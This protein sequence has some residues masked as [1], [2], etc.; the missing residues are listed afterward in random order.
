MSVTIPIT[1]FAPAERV[2]IEVI[3]LQH[4]AIIESPMT[5]ELLN[6]VINYV[7]ILN[8]QRQIVY[9]SSNTSSILLGKSADSILGMRPGEALGCIHKD[10]NTSG[11]GT[12]IFCSECGAVKAML[13]SFQGNKSVQECRLTRIVNLE[14]EAI[15]LLVCAVPFTYQNQK[16]C[17]FSIADV[18]HEKRRRALERIFFHDVINAAG[19]LEGLADLLESEAPVEMRSEL[20]LLKTGLRSLLEEIFAQREL[21]SAENRELPVTLSDISSVEIM[22]QV[23]GLYS[24]HDIAKNKYLRIDSSAILV[25][26][27][28]DATL[29]RRVLGNLAKNALEASRYGDTVTMSCMV[30]DESVYFWVHNP[31]AMPREVQLQIFNRSFSTKGMG[32]GLGTYSVKLLTENYLHG[33]VSFISQEGKGTRFIVQLPLN[34]NVQTKK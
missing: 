22:Q 23:I 21:T 14:A 15:D 8:E 5:N 10:V 2:P 13:E 27:R 33:S 1:E 3:R 31:T 17:I 20:G 32:R 29:L 34:Q 18:S 24:N 12:S 9:A 28:S 30:D 16:Y 7:F 19:G 26:F 4:N 25:S 6:S 11:C